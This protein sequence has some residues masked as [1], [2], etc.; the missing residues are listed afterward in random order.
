MLLEASADVGSMIASIFD[1]DHL[2]AQVVNS[3]QERFN[4]Y[5]TGIYLLDESGRWLVLR[6]ATGDAGAR[7]KATGYRLPLSE[8]TM[9]GATALRR[10]TR[11]AHYTHQ[12]MRVFAKTRLP[13]TR[14]Q[15]V[16]PLLLGE[17]I[18]GVL[19]IRSVEE[20]MFDD[21]DVRAV[22]SMANQIAIAL[23][24]AR[25]FSEEATM[26]EST[27]PL[28]RI[29]RRLAQAATTDSVAS[30]V[31]NSIAET[32]ADGCSVVEFGEWL[33]GAPIQFTYRANWRRVQQ[34]IGET[35][36]WLPIEH[37]PLPPDVSDTLWTIRD[38]LAEESTVEYAEAQRLPYPIRQLLATQGIRAVANIPLQ[39]RDRVLGHVI[40]LR[41][42]PGPFPSGALRLYE[43]LS[44]QAAVAFERARLW[45]DV[46]ERAAREKI[47]REAAIR[48]RAT[49][50][51]DT[52]LQTGASEISTALGLSA[53]DIRIRLADDTAHIGE[54]S[55]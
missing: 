26:L 3:I 55:N 16:L 42:S 19:D 28:F 23:Q 30:A 38:V 49:L 32:G 35:N 9:I 18:L 20:D 13:Y 37:D 36:I 21:D 8:S 14:S 45:D 53:L 43:A 29:N 39:S 5:H 6:E 47:I 22:R 7:M 1:V 48:M 12:D 10:D 17:D 44:S 34:T 27:S 31:V 52:V 24:N 41:N 11:V 46:Q 54:P 2:L 33:G 51:I 50:D 15:M 4:F 25:Q 40:V